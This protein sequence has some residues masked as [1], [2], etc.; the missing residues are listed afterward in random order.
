VFSHHLTSVIAL[1]L[2]IISTI[3]YLI[4]HFYSGKKAG[5]LQLSHVIVIF[6]STTGIMEG[7][8]IVILIFENSAGCMS[9]IDP[10]ALFLG[11]LSLFWV[12]LSEVYK[13]IK[14]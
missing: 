1:V 10:I 9:E 5:G 3:L 2:G 14:G 8:K 11:G 6:V 7:I 13:R 4:V 12:S